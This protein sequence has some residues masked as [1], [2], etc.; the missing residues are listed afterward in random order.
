[1]ALTLN[2][3]PLGTKH[4]AE[5]ANGVLSWEVPYAPGV[6]KA[7]G[8]RDG[9]QSCEFALKTA[10]P[11]NRIELHPYATRL[12]ADGKDVCQVE[13]DVVDAQGVRVPDA[14]Q[15]LAF[16]TGGPAQII[17]L[18]NG[19]LANLEPVKGPSHR[20]YEGRGLAILQSSTNPGV[21]TLAASAPGLQP[22]TLRLESR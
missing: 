6:L 22:A 10:G 4:L 21:V 5:A 11:A 1:V 18:G 7:A 8:L 20:V 2:G 17:G 16:E 15:E 3:E 12:R 9:R 14:G 19:D 13:F